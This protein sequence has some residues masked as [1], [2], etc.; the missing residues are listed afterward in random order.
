MQNV[1]METTANTND[2]HVNS[3]FRRPWPFPSSSAAPADQTGVDTFFRAPP[4]SRRTP[5][6]RGRRRRWH[7]YYYYY[8]YYRVT[9]LTSGLRRHREDVTTVKRCGGFPFPTHTTCVYLLVA[10]FPSVEG[11]TSDR[12]GGGGGHIVYGTSPR[13]LYARNRHVFASVRV[14]CII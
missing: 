1:G 8:V 11:F 4:P 10:P 3:A 5:R 2:I 6:V 9:S 13:V 12:R 14:R 7:Y